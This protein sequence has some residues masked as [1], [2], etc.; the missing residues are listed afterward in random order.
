MSTTSTTARTTAWTAGELQQI[1]AANHLHIAPFRADGVTY[2]TPTYIWSVVLDGAL[3]VRA[4]N[5]Q[6]S[7]W[8][9]A[10][11]RQKAGRVQ[12]ADIAKEVTFSKVEGSVNAQIDEV[13]RAKYQGSR[14]LNAMVGARA[15]GATVKVMPR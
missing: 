7:S 11:V 1:A 3:Y 15:R 5:G 4:Y 8:Y 10:A 6:N 9:Q 14:Y 12:V 13:Y 2:G